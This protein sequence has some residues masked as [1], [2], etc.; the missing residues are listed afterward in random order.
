MKPTPQF[1]NMISSLYQSRQKTITNSD[2]LKHHSNV[3]TFYIMSEILLQGGKIVKQTELF[4]DQ[5]L[6]EVGKNVE[7]MIIGNDQNQVE[8]KK[9]NIM[10]FD[11][12][13]GKGLLHWKVQNSRGENFTVV[14]LMTPDDCVQIKL[15]SADQT[16]QWLYNVCELPNM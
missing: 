10:N 6:I 14:K 4:S 9:T 15:I 8:Y 1:V 11:M 13:E 5:K 3:V 2:Y 16:T 12:H 7:S